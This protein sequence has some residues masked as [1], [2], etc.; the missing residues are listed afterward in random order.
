MYIMLA[1]KFAIPEVCYSMPCL[2]RSDDC[3][4]IQR[5]I[6]LKQVAPNWHFRLVERVLS[7]SVPYK[8]V[9]QVVTTHLHDIVAVQFIYPPKDSLGI[10]LAWIRQQ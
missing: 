7:L 8:S 6:S 10:A 4:A 9:V 2:D 1:Y 5:E 3:T